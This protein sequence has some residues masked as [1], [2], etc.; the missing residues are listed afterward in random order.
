MAARTPDHRSSSYAGPPER[1][2]ELSGVLKQVLDIDGRYLEVDEGLWKT[3]TSG[4]W[5]VRG[6]APR[7]QRTKQLSDILRGELDLPIRLELGTLERPVYVVKGQYQY[8]P[9][10]SKEEAAIAARRRRPERG[11]RD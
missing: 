3:P 9:V 10:L 8:T 2:I 7:E 5:I 11:R 4:D 6:N 1:G